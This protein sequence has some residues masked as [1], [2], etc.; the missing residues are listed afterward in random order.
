M[1]G[2]M[3]LFPGEDPDEVIAQAKVEHKPIRTFC[4]FS[5]GGDSQVLAH[6]CRDHYDELVFLDTTTAL[7][8]VVE[9]VE[10]FAAFVG[11][12]LRLMRHDGDAYRNM[13]LGEGEDKERV[14]NWR[15]LGF[16]GPAQ[17]GRAYNRL[18]ECLVEQLLRE[19]KV[20]H[21]RSDRVLFLTGVRRAESAR[22]AKRLAVTRKG[23]SVFANP[24]IDWDNREMADYRRQHEFPVS[25]IT[26]LLHRSGECNCGAFAALGEREMIAAL[27]PD[28]FEERI[29]SL[30]REAQERGIP[31]CRWGER[32][33]EGV[34]CF[35]L[36]EGSLCEGC[37]QQ[38]SLLD[39]VA[40]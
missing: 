27:W 15:P 28:W 23:G 22:R 17:H 36:P 32:Q 37:E 24:L 19:T 14:P 4:L 2:Q 35:P 25:D 11:K 40:V 12:P 5:G 30:E 21:K 29:A 9:F 20:G 26:A 6:R 7:P 3:R 13:V 39:G 33:P 38:A 16:P 1:E 10:E 18:K 8:G 34:N 31:M